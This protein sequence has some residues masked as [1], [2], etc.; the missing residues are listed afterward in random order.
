MRAL[1]LRTVA[2]VLLHREIEETLHGI[3]RLDDTLITPLIT[4]NLTGVS[5]LISSSSLLL[6]RSSKETARLGLGH[7]ISSP[8]GGEARIQVAVLLFNPNSNAACLVIRLI[9]NPVALRF[10][11]SGPLQVECV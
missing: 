6:L 4:H 10:P 11:F 9:N 3:F 1:Q 2:L 5:P 7:M 8:G